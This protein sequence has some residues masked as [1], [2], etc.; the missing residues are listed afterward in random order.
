MPSD[1]TAAEKLPHIPFYTS[2]WIGEETLKFVGLAARGLWIEM[3]CR[4][5]GS[6]QRGYL[7]DR[8][9][10]PYNAARLAKL[11]GFPLSDIEPLLAELQHE[12]VY[13]VDDRGAIYSRRMVRDEEKRLRQ[14]EDGAKGGRPAAAK[15]RGAAKKDAANDGNLQ[16][17]PVEQ[18]LPFDEVTEEKG[19]P[20]QNTKGSPDND[21]D[22]DSGFEN[23][24]IT[25]TATESVQVEGA[26]RPRPHVPAE[27]ESREAA[28]PPPLVQTQGSEVGTEGWNDFVIAA[29]KARMVL[30][31]TLNSPTLKY[32]WRP[33][34]LE[35]RRDAIQGIH[36][37]IECGQYSDPRFVPSAENYLKN[38]KWRESL[39]VVNA[40]PPSG[41]QQAPCPQLKPGRGAD[42]LRA[43]LA[44]VQQQQPS[45]RADTGPSEMRK[46]S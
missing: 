34:N 1:K 40:P 26:G 16:H 6:S 33:L 3:L 41:G 28:P 4:M 9:G 30:D 29:A 36:R 38:H 14:K 43:K 32:L 12:G 24:Q 45:S 46:A 27:L 42:I 18:E 11:I 35:Q 19:Y 20:F 23:L 7:V 15:R 13:S 2:D 8:Q 25:H 39:R 37:R 5:N 10:R 17:L 44:R 31:A 21:N 22:S